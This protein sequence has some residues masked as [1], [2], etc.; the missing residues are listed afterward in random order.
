M[1]M[2]AEKY[3][4][5]A[6]IANLYVILLCPCVAQ[7]APSPHVALLLN[8]LVRYSKKVVISHL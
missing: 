3:N 6:H 5:F 1:L 8:S 2:S 7:P 4:R